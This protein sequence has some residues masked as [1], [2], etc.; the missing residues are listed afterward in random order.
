MAR[1]LGALRQMRWSNEGNQLEARR[2]VRMLLSSASSLAVLLVLGGTVVMTLSTF[3]F[4]LE[5]GSLQD[6]VWMRRC[7]DGVTVSCGG[8]QMEVSP[9]QSILGVMW[10]TLNRFTTTGIEAGAV[11]TP[12][13]RVISGVTV[14]LGLAMLGLPLLFATSNYREPVYTGVARSEEDVLAGLRERGATRERSC[15]SITPSR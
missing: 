13:G 3:L 12:G 11:L 10:H 7:V 2:F 14:I 4:F 9:F 5:N 1:C 6:G 8:G 15:F